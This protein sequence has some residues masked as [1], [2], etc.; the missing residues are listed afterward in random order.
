MIIS[1]RFRCNRCGKT[2]QMPINTVDPKWKDAQD[3]MKK[4]PLPETCPGCS[5]SEK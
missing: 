1:G 2:R 5:R 3:Q 4:A